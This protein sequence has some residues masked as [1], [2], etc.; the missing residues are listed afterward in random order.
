VQNN[1]SNKSSDVKTII[2]I[3]LKLLIIGVVTAVL[4]ALVNELTK[5]KIA[6][7]TEKEKRGAIGE[8]FTGGIN[9]T[10]YLGDM[11]DDIGINDISIIREN[12]AFVGYVAEVAPVG[13]GGEITL[14]VGVDKNGAVVGVKVISH[15][16]TAGLGSRVSDAAY[17][18]GYKGA[19]GSTVGNVDLISGATISSKAV[20]EGVKTALSAY[21]IVIGGG[22]Q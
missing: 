22:V 13:F 5:D 20:R 17:L 19:D 1:I 2:V 16:E 15:G 9:I 18:E 7:N 10:P 11:P 3:T 4:L 8:L 21:S 12:D 14:M 6:D